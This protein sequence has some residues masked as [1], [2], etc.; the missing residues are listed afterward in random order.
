MAG[1]SPAMY[2]MVAYF[3]DLLWC[4]IASALFMGVV[5]T[6]QVD[7]FATVEDASK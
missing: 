5:Y 2:W 3:L 6:F 7:G 4:F 1:T